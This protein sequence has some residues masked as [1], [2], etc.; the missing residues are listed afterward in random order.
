MYCMV[1]GIWKV[2]FA[3]VPPVE[4]VS[5]CGKGEGAHTPVQRAGIFSFRGTGLLKVMRKNQPVVV[6][7]NF[8][9]KASVK[10]CWFLDKGGWGCFFRH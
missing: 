1:C 10:H 4:N 3:F 2:I 6:W 9:G 7:S 8:G 5:N